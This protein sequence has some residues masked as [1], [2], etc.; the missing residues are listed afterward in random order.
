MNKSAFATI[1][2]AGMLLLVGCNSTKNST[3]D[4]AVN[5]PIETT[6]DLSNIQVT[7]D[8]APVTINP[9]RFTVETV[10]YRLPKVVQ[11]TYSVS[12]FGKYVD[13]FKAIDYKGEAIP[14]VTK[15]D[16]NTWTIAQAKKLDKITYNG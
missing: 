13:D 5:L 7:N 12:D 4:L 14:E 8:K 3:N 16:E 1:A 9:G 6:L 15:L 10:T 11:G 2:F